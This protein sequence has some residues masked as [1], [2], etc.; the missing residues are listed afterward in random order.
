[1]VC[2]LG[3]AGLNASDLELESD[4]DAEAFNDGL[5]LLPAE[6]LQNDLSLAQEV[7]MDHQLWSKYL[8]P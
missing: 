5:L 1:M 6:E 4:S 2:C 7:E 8:D 3:P